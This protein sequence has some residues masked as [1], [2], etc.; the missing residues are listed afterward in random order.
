[1]QKI[2]R[3]WKGYRI[4]SILCRQAAYVELWRRTELGGG[5]KNLGS[6]GNGRLFINMKCRSQRERERERGQE[7]K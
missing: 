3:Y 2:S 4:I 5:I 1:L 7:K 6:H